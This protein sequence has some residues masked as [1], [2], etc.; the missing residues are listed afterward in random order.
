MGE[1]VSDT[2]TAYDLLEHATNLARM[3]GSKEELLA[4]ISAILRPPLENDDEIRTRLI[5]LRLMLMDHNGG[6]L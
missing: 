2:Y 1:D 6:H 4:R 3:L 5:M